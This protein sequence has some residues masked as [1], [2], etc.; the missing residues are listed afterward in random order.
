M[1]RLVDVHAHLNF[2][3]YDRDR[4]EV[5]GR[6]KA[7][8]LAV[9]NVGTDLK[10]SREVVDLA[11]G[12]NFW[13]IVGIHPTETVE[14]TEESWSKL[15]ELALNKN[16]VAIGECGLD[17]SRLNNQVIGEREK[18][19]RK[20]QQDVFERQIDLAHEVGKPLMLHI[21]DAYDET[22]D[23]LNSKFQILKFTIP[24]DVHFFAG[25]TAIA[26][27]FLDLGFVL[28]FTGVITFAK[29][30]EEVVKY[31]PLE[32]MLSETDCPF[33][34]P[35]PYRGKR[36]EP[37]YVSEVVKKIAEIKNRPIDEV[38]EAIWQNAQ[39]L[40]GLPNL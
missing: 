9:I 5:V 2:A 14:I 22:L 25:D 39:N 7:E 27:K 18:V 13:A 24:G 10:T 8:N 4:E 15:K 37:L 1:T 6:I 31:V 35:T 29:E 23:I 17:Y 16:T 38:A 28:S 19:I 40:F 20:Q 3:D 33:V 36:N 34:A 11:D 30:Y 32:R 12:K 21:R 26:K